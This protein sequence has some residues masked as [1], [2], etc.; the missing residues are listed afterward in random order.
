MSIA[1]ISANTT[2]TAM[3]IMFVY[4]SSRPD[5]IPTSIAA[6]VPFDAPFFSISFALNIV[7]TILI[8]S[9]LLLH[10][11]RVQNAMGAAVDVGGLYMATIAI[12]VESYA[13]CAIAVTLY[14]ATWGARSYLQYIFLQIIAQMQVRA[15]F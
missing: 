10:K 4:E 8:V 11:K 1:T 9:R 5:L 6:M 2:D 12:I 7:V 15:L 14:L 13:I 3:G